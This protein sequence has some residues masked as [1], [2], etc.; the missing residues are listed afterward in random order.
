MNLVS[1]QSNS[2]NG[3]A[4]GKDICKAKDPEQ[5]KGSPGRTV[6]TVASARSRLS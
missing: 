4:G 2:D 5:F 1:N 3:S 6:G